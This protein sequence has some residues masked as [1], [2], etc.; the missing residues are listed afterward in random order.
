MT[1]PRCTKIKA[2][3]IDIPHGVALI[4]IYVFYIVVD[5]RNIGVTALT[6]RHK[7]FIVVCAAVCKRKD[8]VHFLCGRQAVML[9]NKARGLYLSGRQPTKLYNKACGICLIVIS[10]V[11]HQAALGSAVYHQARKSESLDVAAPDVWLPA[12]GAAPYLEP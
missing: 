12:K 7:I 11:F 6:Q 1:R 4:V 2:V 8:V 9:Y 3:E 10:F 5:D